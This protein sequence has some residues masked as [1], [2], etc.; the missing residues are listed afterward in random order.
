MQFLKGQTLRERIETSGPMPISELLAT[1][2]QIATGMEAAH[3]QGIVHRDIK[4]ANIFL[5][6]RGLAKLLDFGVAKG[7]GPS[8]DVARNGKEIPFVESSTLTRTG[9]TVGTAAYMSPEQ[10]RREP[11]DPRT[12]L[13]SFGAVLYE[14][15]TGRRAFEGVTPEQVYDTILNHTPVAAGHFNPQIPARLEEIIN[16]TLEKDREKRYDSASGIRADLQALEDCIESHTSTVVELGLRNSTKSEARTVQTGKRARRK[17]E[18]LWA[19]PA[20]VLGFILGGVVLWRTTITPGG[21][22]KITPFSAF[23]GQKTEPAFS[24]DGK[25]V[26]FVWNGEAQDNYDIYVKAVDGGTPMRLTT[27]SAPDFDPAWSPDGRFIAFRRVFETVNDILV[28]PALGGA[29]RK[30]TQTGLPRIS[31][32]FAM[33]ARPGL[34]WSSNGRFLVT[35]DA[36]SPEQTD[37]IISISAET[38]K[39]HDLTSPG[40]VVADSI[41]VISPNSQSVAFVRFP[42]TADNANNI[43]I[44]PVNADGM[45]LGRPRRI[46]RD[47]RAVS[48]LDWLPSGRHLVF[49]STGEDRG[50]S[51]TYITGG[52]WRIRVSGGTPEPLSAVG[53]PMLSFSVAP[54]GERLAYTRDPQRDHNIYELSLSRKNHGS[55]GPHLFISSTESDYSPRFSPDGTQIALVSARSG[56]LEIWICRSDGSS[57]APLTSFGGSEVGSPA[58]SPDGRQ[59]AFDTLRDGQWN[60]Y[61]ADVEKRTTRRLTSESSADARPSWSK[62]GQWI[63]FASDRGGDWQVWKAPSKGGLAVQVTR[64]GGFEAVESLDGKY[65]YYAKRRHNGLWRMPVHG[66][67]EKQ[68][69]ERGEEGQW[70]LTAAGIYLLS[71]DSK[72]GFVIQFSKFGARELSQIVTLPLGGAGLYNPLMPS[73]TVSSDGQRALYVQMD[74]SEA[75][76]IMVENFRGE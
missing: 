61:V 69:L 67:G 4:P 55:N 27:H 2:I 50:G 63:Y 35:T 39:K 57:C 75:D 33:D 30:L 25:R 18:W 6:D 20:A 40:T 34:S 13:F 3:E 51:A 76:I 26:A 16:R 43:Y 37:K 64:K 29:E 28:I 36:D 42:H 46:T 21:S 5:T 45:P 14:M 60:I 48:G 10:I 23:P 62:D 53:A 73:L 52:L 9:A 41:P 17:R 72:L 38:G 15:A 19:G 22:L 7:I 74:H 70:C 56:P 11:L 44:Q 12:D 49:S 24:P 32:S 47:L 65:L 66:E 31:G 8:E 1:A 54:K 59:L 68:I 58:W 71:R